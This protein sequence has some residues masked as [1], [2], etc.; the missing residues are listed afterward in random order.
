MTD[1]AVPITQRRVEAFTERYLVALGATVTKTNDR[2]TVTLPETA[3]TDLDLQNKT[4]VCAPV[5]DVAPGERV[6]SPE[7][8][9]FHRI[10][11]DAHRHQPIG[12]VSISTS[13]DEHRLPAWLREGRLTI[14]STD[15]IPYYDRHAIVALFRV[16]IETVSEYQSEVLRAVAVDLQTGEALPGLTETYLT[17]TDPERSLL[18]T[19]SVTPATDRLQEALHHGR[20]IVEEQVR[21]TIDETLQQ[22]SR[23]ADVELEEYRQL[24]QQRIKE[25]RDDVAT[26]DEQIEQLNDTAERS[27]EREARVEALRERKALR[28]ERDK[29]QQELE[30][31]LAARDAGFPEKQREIRTRHALDVTI[32]P[33]LLTLVKYEKGELEVTIAGMSEEQT[34]TLSYGCGIGVT[35]KQTC[36]NCDHALD[37]EN[38][39]VLRAGELY[40]ENCCRPP[41]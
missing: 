27:G 37:A 5:D 14:R 8:E 33:R 23:A 24:Q 19:T 16:S 41:D 12:A 4:I 34:I 18:P 38:P 26:L 1:A 15:M 6:L 13:H 39:A 32:E 28:T 3:E 36:T 11:D 17:A 35:E 2:W 21:P 31:L 22:A 40:G 29:V 9:F 10:L 20:E 25:L 7:S 30:A